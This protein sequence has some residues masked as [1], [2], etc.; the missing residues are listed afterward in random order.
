MS[1]FNKLEIYRQTSEMAKELK[2]SLK[3]MPREYKFDIGNEIKR[4]V[5]DMKY[6]IYLINVRPDNE[7]LPYLKTFIDMYNHLKI[8]IDDCLEDNVLSLKGKYTIYS[9]LKRLK[10][11]GEQANKWKR[12][13]EGIN[14]TGNFLKKNSNTEDEIF[15]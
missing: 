11:I 3:R 14:R 6:Q 15:K 5:R 4:L 13:I 10:S 7:K 12:Y 2:P 9:P 1:V 8:L